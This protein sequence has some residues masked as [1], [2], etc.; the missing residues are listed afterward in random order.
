M[1]KSLRGTKE[2]SGM[3]KRALHLAMRSLENSGSTISSE[4]WGMAGSRRAKAGLGGEGAAG[5]QRRLR[6]RGGGDQDSQGHQDN[7][8]SPL[9]HLGRPVPSLGTGGYSSFLIVW[10]QVWVM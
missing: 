8:N 7:R 1:L 10:G 2:P 5:T 4:W 3:E 6:K 9:H